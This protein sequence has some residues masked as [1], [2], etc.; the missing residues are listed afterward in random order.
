MA[1]RQ[2]DEANRLGGR[3]ARYARV[4]TN[5]GGLAARVAGTR[6]FG[7]E[8]G[9]ARNAAELAAALGGLK[10]P[11]MKVA[12][13]LATVPDLLPP[14][15]ATE[16]AKLQANAPPMGWAFAK[17]RLQAELGAGW[18]SRFAS[19]DKEPAAAAS[20]GQV[21]RAISLEGEQ[22]AC[23]LQYPEMASAVEA[24]LAQLGII[25]SI[26]RRFSPEIDTR[27]IA[28]EIGERLREE[29]DYKREA[30][31]IALYSRIL[32]DEPLVRV[33]GV[34]PELSTARLLTMSWLDGAPL[35]DFK[36]HSLNDRNLL[37]RALFFA[38][39]RPFVRYGVIHGDPHLGNYSVFSEGQRPAGIN[40]LDY[41]SIRVFPPTFVAGV[42]GL[43]LGLRTGDRDRIVAAYES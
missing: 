37:A 39:W 4:G 14:E 6:L 11:L 15:F 35:L 10:G 42:L 2:D 40:L 25:L 5:V 1:F 31:H 43:Y 12:Q 19:F 30:K 22:L 33:P 38:W 23:K 28:K 16:L 26:Q 8:L 21:H 34:V 9:D 7:R 17:R 29:L 3:L 27:E 20:L 32:R 41:G 18:Q 24:D 36:R 13:L